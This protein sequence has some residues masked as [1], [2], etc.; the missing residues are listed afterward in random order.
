MNGRD[1]SYFPM[2]RGRHEV[3]DRGGRR[4]ASGWPSLTPSETEVVQLPAQGL[5]NPQIAERLFISRATVKTHL[6]HVFTKLGVTAPAR[7]AAE[8]TRLA[9]R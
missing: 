9:M 5:T 2:K 1:P 6:I 3:R 7:L 4:P 8:A